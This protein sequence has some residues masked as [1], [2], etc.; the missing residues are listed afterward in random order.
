MSVAILI[1][2]LAAAP[3]QRSDA[4]ILAEA[5][6]AFAEGVR[7]R[8][9]AGAARPHFRQA[10]EDFEELRR[11]GAD[12]AA[13]YRHL[14]HSW[15]LAGELPRAILAYRKGL[16][17]WPADYGLRSDLTDARDQV[18]FPPNTRLG[19]PPSDQRRLA[20]VYFGAFPLTVTGALLYTLA[21]IC[22]T[23]WRITGRHRLFAAAL[24]GL[25]GTAAAAVLVAIQVRDAGEARIRPL[26]VIAEDGVLLRRGDGLRFPQRYDTPLNRGVE[27]RLLFERDDWLQI[28]LSGGE[29]GWIPRGYALVDRP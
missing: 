25:A 12:T 18:V 27:A 21:C 8:D 16:Q 17:R 1:T 5:A 11:R 15:L 13:L 6:A 7:L 19:L 20:W 24:M 26:V 9:D 2:L 23:G 4:E 28:E 14:G 22:L 10:A 29:V 3:A